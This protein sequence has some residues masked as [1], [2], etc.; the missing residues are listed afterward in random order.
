MTK[1]NKEDILAAALL[2]KTDALKRLDEQFQ[3]QAAQLALAKSE[4]K[5]FIYSA[6]HDLRAPLRNIIGFGRLL[7]RNCANTLPPKGREYLTQIEVG[8]SKMSNLIADLLVLS[9]VADA[10]FHRESVDLSEMANAIGEALRKR[11]PKR[12]VEFKIAPDLVA[13]GDPFLLKIAMEN[14]I[15]NAWKY[16]SK[17]TDAIIEVGAVRAWPISSGEPNLQIET[18]FVRDN[19]HG[20]DMKYADKLFVPFERLHPESEFPGTGIGLAIVQRI[21]ALHRG[22]IFAESTPETCATFYFTLQ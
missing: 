7:T 9:Q 20:F 14:L 6:S 22:R 16:T 17:R 2:E 15:G 8:V 11:V 21:I 18:Y 4:L 13:Y 10:E 3:D 5:A 1:L 19:G 12:D